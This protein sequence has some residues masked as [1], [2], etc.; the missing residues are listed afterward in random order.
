M[1]ENK[2]LCDT[3]YGFRPG[4]SC[5]HA[6][7]NA[8]NHILE[9]LSKKQ[10]ALLLL[11]DFSKAFDVVEHSI[12]L[13]K[14][15]HYGVR[16]IAFKWIESYLND[17]KQFVNINGTDSSQK[18]IEYGVPQGSVLGPL[19]F[20]IYIND[21]PN[22]SKFAH[23]IL[24]ADDANIIVTGQNVHEVMLKVEQLCNDI[25]KWVDNNGLALNLKKTKYMVFSRQRI[26]TSNIEIK[27]NKVKIEE[28]NESRF[29]GVIMD[30]KLN[31]SQHIAAVR[32]KMS[33]YI[34]VMYKIKNR[35]P[36]QVR[37]QIFQSFVQ[38]HLNYCSL[39]WGYAAKSHIESLFR[40]QKQGM[41]AIMPGYVNYWYNDGE[42]PAHT[43]LSFK[44]HGILTVHSIIAMNTLV[45]L[46]KVSRFPNSLPTSIVKTIPCNAPNTG[47]SYDDC[48]EW[49]NKY[50]NI[51]YRT[52]IFH[53]GPLLAVSPD[54]ADITSDPS[55][56]SSINRYKKS[57]KRFLLDKQSSGD[58]DIWPN[59]ILYTIPGLRISNRNTKYKK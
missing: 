38:S 50:N 41:R 42:L 29:L 23:F 34:G 16:G 43:K 2:V 59:F 35:L 45:F 58:D 55:T 9:A 31:W 54:V 40:K 48:I 52:T 1:D 44:K 14:L 56:L 32:S 21:L 37:V 10:V 57:T 8:N 27:I 24:Y 12:L 26:D 7:L 47:S 51:P 36:L 4:R 30:N 19:L 11:I 18:P 6:L 20:I 5:E 28:K 22:I 25:V 46:H 39:V 17:R 15:Q 49:S 13:H 53:K 33:K 3:Q